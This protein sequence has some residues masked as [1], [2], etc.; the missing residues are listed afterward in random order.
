L[1]YKFGSIAIHIVNVDL[2]RRVN[3]QQNLPW[4]VARKQYEVLDA[5]GEVV[6]SAPNSCFK[7]EQFIF[8]AVPFA[9]RA[10]FVETLREEEFAPVKNAEGTDS[11][12]TA[13]KLMQERWLRWLREAG[14][15]VPRDLEADEAVVEISP[16]F[17][18][19]ADE[20]KELTQ[21][22]GEPSFPL[23]LEP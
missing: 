23:I 10:A 19:D 22:G 2:I 16:L 11:P 6:L 8:D 7:F 1:L 3:A 4:H 18:A 9:R 15:E 17:A 14:I 12:A 5:R 21:S 13:R 20:L